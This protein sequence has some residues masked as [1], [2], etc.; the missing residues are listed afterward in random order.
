[1]IGCLFETTT[2]VVAKPLVY[3][4]LQNESAKVTSVENVKA[5]LQLKL[6]DLKNKVEN[7]R[8]YIAR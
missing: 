1:M 8:R 6:T 2:C 4:I 5:E 3:I 7:Q